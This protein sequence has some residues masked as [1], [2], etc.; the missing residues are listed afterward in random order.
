MQKHAETEEIIKCVGVL[1]PTLPLFSWA[2]DDRQSHLDLM[3]LLNL[4][5]TGRF[6]ENHSCQV[7][8]DFS[9]YVKSGLLN[10]DSRFRKTSQ[11]V[12]VVQVKG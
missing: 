11:C 6:G 10:K 5:P 4:F 2:P 3:C 12:Q 7:K 1:H 9:E 8:L